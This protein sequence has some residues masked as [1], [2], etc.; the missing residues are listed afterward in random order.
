MV[1]LTP[2]Q[3]SALAAAAGLPMTADDVTE[4]THRLN[5]F[6]EALSPLADL[7]LEAVEPTPFSVDPVPFAPAPEAFGPI[8]TGDTRGDARSVEGHR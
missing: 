1:D 2:D 6:L 7:P 4:V 8:G 3:V 5:A